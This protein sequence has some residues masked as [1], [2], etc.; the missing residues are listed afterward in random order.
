MKQKYG[1]TL[2]EL[3]VVIAIIGILSAIGLTAFSGAQS[4]A[5]DAKRVSDLRA[6]AGNII[7]WASNNDTETVPLQPSAALVS[8]SSLASTSAGDFGSVYALPIAPDSSSYD[9]LGSYFYVT[10]SEGTMYALF[11]KLESGTKN[12]FVVN[13]FGYAA[14]VPLSSG[15]GNDSTQWPTRGGMNKTTACPTAPG[16][17]Y[18]YVCRATPTIH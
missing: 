15:I 16:T 8:L 14:E 18:Y 12:W 11:T 9:N 17:I 6:I 2:I 4:K 7:I 13:S 1:F 3:L 5:R 10:N